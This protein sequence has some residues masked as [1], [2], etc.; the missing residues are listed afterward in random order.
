MFLSVLC[1]TI[2]SSMGEAKSIFSADSVTGVTTSSVTC[3]GVA[4]G[5]GF[6]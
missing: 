2:A 4:R 3:A 5:E 6:V 1:S